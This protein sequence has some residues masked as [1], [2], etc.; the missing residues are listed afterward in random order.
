MKKAFIIIRVSEED[1]LKGY[2]PDVQADEVR[3]YLSQVGLEEIGHRVIQEES[4]T[5]DRPQFE[6]V[7]DEAIGL[8]RR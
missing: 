1:Q 6:V 5:G 8:K 7:L 4:T 2:G 3:T